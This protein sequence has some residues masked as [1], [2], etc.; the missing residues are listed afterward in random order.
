MSKK[1]QINFNNILYLLFIISTMFSI[2][3]VFQN[4]Q[5]NFSIKFIIFYVIFAVLF[6]IYIFIVTILKMLK[7]GKEE[8][9]KRLSK[10]IIIFIGFGG[11]NYAFD[12]ILRPE[13]INLYRNF[14]ISFG[15]ALN[16]I[17][18]DLIFFKK[19]KVTN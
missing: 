7:L 13:N 3:I 14:S 2:F 8:F 15:L 10:F 12:Y 5:S 19:E 17:C 18:F 1:P 4:I 9:K 11:I 6:G 16:A